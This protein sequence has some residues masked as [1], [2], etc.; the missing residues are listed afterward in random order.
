MT[1]ATYY[2]RA[3]TMPKTSRE[4]FQNFVQMI[5][6]CIESGEHNEAL[7]KAVDLLDTISGKASPYTGVTDE[8]IGFHRMISELK[9]KH[10]KDMAKAIAT[11]MKDGIEEGRKLQRAETAKRLGLL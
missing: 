10:Q 8:A 3:I 6:N 9:D 7:L 1:N 5:I 11:A 2:S 4:G